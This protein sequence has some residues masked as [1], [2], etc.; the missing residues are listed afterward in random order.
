MCFKKL[1]IESTDEII[2]KSI[3]K[4]KPFIEK[5]MSIGL[6]PWQKSL[7]YARERYLKSER[8]M[9]IMARALYDQIPKEN[10]LSTF[11]AWEETSKKEY[12]EHDEAM[13]KLSEES[14]SQLKELR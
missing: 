6:Q 11:E 9:R 12:E 5:A 8:I 1:K 4:E 3:D 7:E 2:K 14:F 10:A 13:K